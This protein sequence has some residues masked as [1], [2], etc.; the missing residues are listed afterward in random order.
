MNGQI[1]WSD[2]FLSAG[3]RSPRAP[4]LLAAA[5][6]LGLAA[7]YEAIVGSTLHWF[8]GWF[9]YPALFY[10]GACVLSK[11]LHDRGRSGWWAA[12][13]LVAV[14]AVWPQPAGFFDFLFVAVL[15]WAGVE[16]GAMPGEMGANRYGPNPLRAALT[17]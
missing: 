12:L 3:G 9:I 16:L 15:V 2:L 4:S 14:V 13:I 6:L 7:L 10:S 1:D 17:A 5:I 8:T 11:R